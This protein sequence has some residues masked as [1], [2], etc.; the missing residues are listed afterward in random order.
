MAS[1]QLRGT[2]RL[3]GQAGLRNAE[4][5]QALAIGDATVK[6]HVNPLLARTGARDR[7][8]AVRFAY[9]NGLVAPGEATAER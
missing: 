6:S 5:A 7:A 1:A 8:Q 9:E 2:R 4:I 3:P